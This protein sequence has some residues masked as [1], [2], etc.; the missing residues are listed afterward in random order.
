MELVQHTIAQKLGFKFMIH[1]YHGDATA[2]ASVWQHSKLHS[3]EVTS[4][5]NTVVVRD[6]AA[7]GIVG[8]IRKQLQSIGAICFNG[9]GNTEQLS[10]EGVKFAAGALCD[11]NDQGREGDADAIATA[12]TAAPEATQVVHLWLPCTDG[13]TDE[14]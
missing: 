8:C 11:F 2:N 6:R 9:S 7:E 12:A 14:N 10:V 13:G 1:V 3:L 4:I 5:Y